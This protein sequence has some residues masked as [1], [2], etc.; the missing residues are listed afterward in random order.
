LHDESKWLGTT[1][2]WKIRMIFMS[3]LDTS[4]ATKL[5]KCTLLF[6]A[7]HV[8][9]F[10]GVVAPLMALEVLHLGSTLHFYEIIIKDFGIDIILE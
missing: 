10:S 1:S 7:D 8:H 4:A 9:Y 3:L 2:F 5:L 6:E